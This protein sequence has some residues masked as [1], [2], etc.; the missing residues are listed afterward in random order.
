MERDTA[1]QTAESERT[2]QKRSRSKPIRPARRPSRERG[3]ESMTGPCK[4][5]GA[6]SWDTDEIRGETS[7]SQ[8]GYVAAENMIDPGAEWINHSGGDDRSRVGAPTT[9][10]LS[11]KG[12]STEIRRSDLTAGAARRHGMT[13]KGL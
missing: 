11:D 3:T 1:R 6:N 9:L 2:S 4:V 7:C 8:C 5:C 13:G 10:T 12:L